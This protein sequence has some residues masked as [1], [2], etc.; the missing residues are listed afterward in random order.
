MTRASMGIKTY[1]S[2][3]LRS[4]CKR[5]RSGLLGPFEFAQPCP[6]P[7]DALCHGPTFQALWGLLLMGQG[8]DRSRERPQKTI[9]LP[10]CEEE[11]GHSEQEFL[12]AASWETSSPL[13]PPVRSVC[14]SQKLP[15]W[16]RWGGAGY[17]LNNAGVP[18]GRNKAGQ[19]GG[20]SAPVLRREGQT[21]PLL[22]VTPQQDQG[23]SQA[24]RKDG[25]PGWGQAGE[26]RPWAG[27]KRGGKDR[28]ASHVSRDVP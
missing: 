3:D 1:L 21:L 7:P 23:S 5:K 18:A 4:G 17:R 28:D 6:S 14:N 12:P 22:P 2:P 20:S 26:K 19:W 8:G 16:R 25:W 27:R 24:T 10:P 9:P 13:Q 11:S 15:R